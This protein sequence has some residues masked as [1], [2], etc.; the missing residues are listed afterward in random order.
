MTVASASLRT[1]IR[2]IGFVGVAHGL[3]HFY[4][5]VIPPLF[6]LL[7]AEF[8]VSYAREFRRVAV[9]TDVAWI[10]NLMHLFAPLVH[11]PLR[12]FPLA[13]LAAAQ[14]WVCVPETAT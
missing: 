9:V 10:A 3:S 1:D 12:V 5:L 8:G 7:R 13:S 11:A 6:P 4:H 2:V 14:H